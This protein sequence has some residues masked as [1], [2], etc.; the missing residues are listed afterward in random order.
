MLGANASEN[1]DEENPGDSS[2]G[3]TASTKEMVVDVIQDYRL[4]ETGFKKKDY[5]IHLKVCSHGV[6]SEGNG[7][8]RNFV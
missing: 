4:V 6:Y 2:G 8:W 5:Q 7:S 1:P 3:A